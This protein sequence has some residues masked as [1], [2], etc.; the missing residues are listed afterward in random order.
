MKSQAE[1]LF[2]KDTLQSPVYALLRKASFIDFPG[3][4]CR[5]LFISGCNLR[6]IFCHNF[7][8]IKPKKTNIEWTRLEKILLKSRENWI[9]AVCITGGEPTLHPQLKELIIRLK[10]LGLKVKLDTNGSLPEVLRELLPIVDYLAM[11]YKA[12]L[13]SYHRVTACPGLKLEKITESKELII[14]W[15]GEYEFRTTVVTGLHTEEDML[16]IC[17]ELEG[18]R[19]Y[20]LQSFVPAPGMNDGNGLPDKRTPMSMLR[21]YHN[22]CKGHFEETILRGE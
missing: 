13:E 21:Q 4:L 16:T 5:V 2:K 20:V 15:D 1:T 18:A 22:L 11:D 14:D 9:D 3:H 19:R 10:E 12:P 7:E 17:R 8:L 6:C